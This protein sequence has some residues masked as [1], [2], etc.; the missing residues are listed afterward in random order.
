MNTGIHGQPGV[1]FNPALPTE[2]LIINRIQE[3]E[4]IFTLQLRLTDPEQQWRL[5]IQ[6]GQFNMLYRFG[7]GEIPISFKAISGDE[8][9][10]PVLEHTIRAVGRVSRAFMALEPG[11]SIG[12]RGPFGHGW[13]LQQAEGMDLCVVTGGLGCAPAVSVIEHAFSN[14]DL[15]G[16]IHIIQGVKHSADLLWRSRYEFWA[17]QPNTTVLMAADVAAPGWPWF[18][19]R[20][21]ELIKRLPLNPD[22]TLV[23][24]CGPEPMMQASAEQLIRQQVP[25][26][27][28]WLS[29]E[30]NMQCATGHCGHCQFGA[31]FICREGPVM[32][33][34]R[35]RDRL[36]LEG[37]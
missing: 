13:P 18:S 36:G 28:I 31:D 12:L 7:V 20:V 15:Y 1:G 14:R 35:L 33:Y 22:Q 21:T 23:C 17:Q 27:S 5:S 19:G 37:V 6:P 29:M 8:L 9:N 32:P 11:T 24:C 4:D 2:A 34:P 16:H 3:T 25:A 26:E 30:R 10:R